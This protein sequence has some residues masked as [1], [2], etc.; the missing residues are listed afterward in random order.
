MAD[1]RHADVSS[2]KLNERFM[3]Y[4]SEKEV[5]LD[6]TQLVPCSQIRPIKPEGVEKL[7]TNILTNGWTPSSRVFVKEPPPSCKKALDKKEYGVIDGMHRTEALKSLNL[8]KPEGWVKRQVPV[9]IPALVTVL[10]LDQLHEH[11]STCDTIPSLLG[12]M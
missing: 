12:P 8:E 5:F 2:M 3:L 1:S 9:T 11:S 7:K 4:L 6:P 10:D